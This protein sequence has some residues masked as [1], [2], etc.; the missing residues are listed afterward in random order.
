MLIWKLRNY[1]ADKLNITALAGRHS[2][3]QFSD[4][5]LVFLPG[6]TL[7]GIPPE[8]RENPSIFL[9]IPKTAGST[10]IAIL[11]AEMIEAKSAYSRAVIQGYRPP[12]AII[13]GWQG[14]WSNVQ[15]RPDRY[16]LDADLISG[17]FP[18][19]VHSILGGQYN[20]FT[21]VREPIARELSTFNYLYQTGAIEK[22]DDFTEFALRMVDNPQVRMIAGASSM[23]GPC[24]EAMYQQAIQNLESHFNLYGPSEKTDEVLN[25]LVS[26]YGWPPVAYTSFNITKKKI[27]DVID[28][29]LRQQLAEKHHFDTRLHHYVSAHW[30]QFKAEHVEAEHSLKA[31]DTVMLLD[32]DFQKTKGYQMVDYG[33]IKA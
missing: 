13:P 18:F 5:K 30:E 26:L 15:D 12:I 31:G 8:K 19:G 32:K 22:E 1:I 10:V 24:D 16:F 4:D 17:H 33:K 3:L 28:D 27:V 14:A 23:S 11:E 25:V 7:K 9:H 20:Y 21:V 6:C 2:E 29:K